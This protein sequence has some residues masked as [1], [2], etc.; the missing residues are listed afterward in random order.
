MES[1][2]YLYLISK[3]FCTVLSA[4]S[5]FSQAYFKFF[6]GYRKYFLTITSKFCRA[7]SKEIVIQ[8]LPSSALSNLW[9]TSDEAS[10]KERQMLYDMDSKN[11]E[12]IEKTGGHKKIFRRTFFDEEDGE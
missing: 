2:F 6:N 1:F 8:L 4:K 10:D 7:T 3:S 5:Y 12:Y 9:S 11:I